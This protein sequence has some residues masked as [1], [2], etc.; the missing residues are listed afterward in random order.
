MMPSVRQAD[1]SEDIKDRKKQEKAIWA[2]KIH[3]FLPSSPPHPQ[4]PA[5]LSFGRSQSWWQRPKVKEVEQIREKE[6]ICI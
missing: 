4:V 6:T 2:L 1:K 5:S 3:L